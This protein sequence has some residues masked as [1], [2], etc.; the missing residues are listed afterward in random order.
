MTE[1]SNAEKAT[2]ARDWWDKTGRKLLVQQFKGNISREK[3]RISAGGRIKIMGDTS[4]EIK[5]GISLGL[6][7]V[8]LTVIEQAKVISAWYTHKY[9]GEREKGL[10]S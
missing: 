9:L 1:M 8:Q 5:T 3:E 4:P 6:P 2:A 7:W 10:L